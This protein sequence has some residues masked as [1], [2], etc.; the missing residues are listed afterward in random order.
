ML[1]SRLVLWLLRGVGLLTCGLITRQ[2]EYDADLWE[3]RLVGSTPFAA[4]M[5]RVL[6]LDLAQE[7]A[8]RDL[9]RSL[10]DGR[11]ADDFTALVLLAEK[12]IDPEVLRKVRHL[13]ETQGTGPFAS[14]PSNR[15]RIDA[16]LRL[17]YPGVFES[18]RPAQC[19]FKGFAK[20]S[21]AVSYDFY[22]L[23]LGT[24]FYRV[25]LVATDELAARLGEEEK[26]DKATLRYF[27]GLLL[28]WRPMRLPQTLVLPSG[29]LDGSALE[30]ARKAFLDGLPR[31]REVLAGFSAADD[32]FLRTNVAET[33]ART[34]LPFDL[35]P[36]GVGNRGLASMLRGQAL[37][38]RDGWERRLG[39]CEALGWRRMEIGLSMLQSE[40]VDAS[41]PAAPAL[42]EDVALMLPVCRLLSNLVPELWML[43]DQWQALRFLADWFDRAGLDPESAACVRSVLE[44]RT[45]H[46]HERI[47]GLRAALAETPYPFDH[48]SGPIAL[49]KYLLRSLPD[50]EDLGAVLQAGA[51]IQQG[52]Q[53]VYFRALGVLALAA[54][55]LEGAMGLKP[56]SLPKD[57]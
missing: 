19:L 3:I 37:E 57:E 35:S 42:R 29:P 52:F 7:Y 5:R 53:M 31:Y 34:G 51:D 22:R 50:S 26:K 40:A 28:P 49:S 32:E 2:M 46:M 33:L 4:T 44:T 36:L 24:G 47:S 25:K 17:E 20:L 8:F 27:Q 12:K 15:D 54:E 56:L 21:R 18:K 45:R 16:A 38:A 1:L 23:A 48:A 9:D 6:V 11:L 13:S 43:R 30:A 10:D 55:E 41:L 39:D 14:H